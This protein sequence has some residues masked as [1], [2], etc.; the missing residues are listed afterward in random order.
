M[1][2]TF[3]GCIQ[4]CRRLQVGATPREAKSEPSRPPAVD[5]TPG[6]SASAGPTSP[7]PTAAANDDEPE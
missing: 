5:P 7:G 2:F 6:A 1:T 4:T 3:L